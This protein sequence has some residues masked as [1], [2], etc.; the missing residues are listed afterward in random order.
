MEDGNIR[1]FQITP[2]VKN[3]HAKW[4]VFW[5]EDNIQ[6]KAYFKNFEG[7]VQQVALMLVTPELVESGEEI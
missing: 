1:I 7:A 3:D 2:T 4:L 5:S 6:Q